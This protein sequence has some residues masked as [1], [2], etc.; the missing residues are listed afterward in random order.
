MSEHCLA[1]SGKIYYDLSD[2]NS[3]NSIPRDQISVL[4]NPYGRELVCEVTTGST[5][6]SDIVQGR[7]K[8][9]SLTHFFGNAY[10]LLFNGNVV[11][12]C[13][14][15]TGKEDYGLQDSLIYT[16]CTVS[17]EDAVFSPILP[18][19]DIELNDIEEASN[20]F[21]L[22]KDPMI[23]SGSL[24]IN[25]L[26]LFIDNG[27]LIVKCNARLEG[28]EYPYTVGD[29]N[30]IM[31]KISPDSI[32]SVQ[33]D[34]ELV[35]AGCEFY[36]DSLDESQFVINLIENSTSTEPVVSKV[37]RRSILPSPIVKDSN[38]LNSS[39]ALDGRTI[40]AIVFPIVM[41]AVILFGACVKYKDDIFN[42]VRKCIHR[43][44]IGVEFDDNGEVMYTPRVIKA[45]PSSYQSIV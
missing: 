11:G 5:R 7:F 31:F 23:T 20:Q 4:M 12:F 2:Y 42:K 10:D 22:Y 38:T 41:L 8:E 17:Y 3:A 16:P 33:Q 34:K 37:E 9:S 24:S 28:I 45:Q 43:N 15:P 40:V 39:S 18:I 1:V 32:L 21:K 27:G 44:S 13:K 29:H 6:R 14:P 30:V 36:Y 35:S 19:G 25:Y 26:R